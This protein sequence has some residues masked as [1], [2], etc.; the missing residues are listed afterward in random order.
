[1]PHESTVNPEDPMHFTS[2]GDETVQTDTPDRRRSLY[3]QMPGGTPRLNPLLSIQTHPDLPLHVTHDHDNDG[4][5]DDD[6]D[7]IVRTESNGNVDARPRIMY[8][9]PKRKVDQTIHESDEKQQ[10]LQ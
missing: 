6:E 7:D 10:A 8:T 4:D 5:P 3:G 9:P 1:M 2:W